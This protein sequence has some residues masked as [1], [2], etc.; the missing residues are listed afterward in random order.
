VR[1]TVARAS[2]FDCRTFGSQ[3]TLTRDWRRNV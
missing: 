3:N 2:W 1:N